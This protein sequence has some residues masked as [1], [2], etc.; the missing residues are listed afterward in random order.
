M[1]KLNKA[2]NVT[3][4]F[5]SEHEEDIM[6]SGKT[7]F[8]VLLAVAAIFGALVWKK[9]GSG[10]L[11]SSSATAKKTDKDS[12]VKRLNDEHIITIHQWHVED[13]EEKT[14][15]CMFQGFDKDPLYDGSG[16][17][18]TILDPSGTSVYEGRF[19]E[20]QRVY[21]TTAL[22]GL[23]DQLVIEA[24]YGG[25]T[26]FLHMLDY[27]NGKV[28][29]LINEKER[30]FDVGAEVRPQFRSGISP[31]TEPF[32]I[33][34]THGVG[35]TS[36]A[37]KYTSVYRYKDGRYRLVGEFPQQQ[38]DDYIEG[39]LRQPKSESKLPK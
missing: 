24:G 21:S 4:D 10:D 14:L 16:V 11:A 28:V 39:L 19:S 12:F 35:L 18:L 27:R 25:S 15:L 17:K 7:I 5:W 29:E 9:Y 22:R 26:S 1:R 13:N 3:S 6:A 23:S 37:R 30:D 8:V 36:P 38:V 32:Q 33:M 20:V 2:L 31:A 34:L